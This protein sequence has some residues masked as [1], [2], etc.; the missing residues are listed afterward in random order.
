MWSGINE[1]TVEENKDK[2]AQI[3]LENLIHQGLKG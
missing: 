3:V 2:L 1:K